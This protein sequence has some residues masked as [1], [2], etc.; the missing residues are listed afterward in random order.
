MAASRAAKITERKNNTSNTI[1]HTMN[2]TASPTADR[3]LV[4]TRVINAPQELVFEAWTTPKH[5]INWWGPNGFTTT[6][7]EA[8]IK[9]GGR[10]KFIMHGPD[11]I[12]YPNEIVYHEIIPYSKLR[13]GHSN[14]EDPEGFRFSTTVTFEEAGNGKTKVTMTGIFDSKETLE[15]VVRDFGAKKG[16]EETMAKM[17]AYVE[18]LNK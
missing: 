11:G 13:Y 2:T 7:Q 12:D 6:N 9:V 17:G 10:W 16:G 4:Q 3:E 14:P 18:Q 8:D 5:L 1:T 15:M